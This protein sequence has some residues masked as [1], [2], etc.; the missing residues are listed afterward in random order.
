MT[1]ILTTH[2]FEEAESLCRNIAI[3]NNGVLVEQSNMKKLLSKAK[4][5]VIII[6]TIEKLP[7]SIQITN[8]DCEIIDEN[9]LQVSQGEGTTISD[10]ISA[11]LAQNI[12]VLHLRSSQNRLESLF[13]SLTS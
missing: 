7:E 8:C 4:R 6:D 5:Q 9:T 2:Y 1:I 10:V 12:N 3:L 11:L 13:L